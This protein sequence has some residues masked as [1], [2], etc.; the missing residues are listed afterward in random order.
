MKRLKIIWGIVLVLVVW[1]VI[2]FTLKPEQTPSS[3]LK[4]NQQKQ[5]HEGGSEL[6]SSSVNQVEGMS[7]ATDDAFLDLAELR[8][9]YPDGV[10]YLNIDHAD[11]SAEQKSM[12]KTDIQNLAKYGSFGGNAP[13][14]NEF[15]EKDLE[16]LRKMI[17]AKEK[18]S[19]SPMQE[20]RFVPTDLKMTGQ[21]Y[22]GT[23]NEKEGFDAYTRLFENTSNGKKIEVSEMYLNPSNNTILDVF[24]ESRNADLEGVSMTWQTKP[25]A[26]G[27][28]YT[29]DF[30]IHS[31]KYSVSTV[32]YS[33][34][35]SKQIVSN[36]IQANR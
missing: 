28:Q 10:R 27:N 26:T 23:Y 15:K 30:V 16:Q 32:G 24:K 14:Q 25:N 2:I 3:T 19:F 20:N 5:D 31:K 33:E 11:V 12:L 34:A 1:G 17:N 18:L 6:R 35:E 21:Y 8:K 13:D 9:R 36:L 7:T 22:S 29:A 4:Q